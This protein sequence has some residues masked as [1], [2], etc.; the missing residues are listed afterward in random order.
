MCSFLLTWDQAHW[1][2]PRAEGPLLWS[3]SSPPPPP[4]LGWPAA[5]G[6]AGPRTGISPPSFG[7]SPASRNPGWAGS[8]WRH[9][10]NSLAEPEEN[11]SMA[12][13]SDLERQHLMFNHFNSAVTMDVLN[14]RRDEDLMECWQIPSSLSSLNQRGSIPVATSFVTAR[15]FW[16][17]AREVYTPQYQLACTILLHKYIWRWFTSLWYLSDL[18]ALQMWPELQCVKFHTHEFVSPAGVCRC[19]CS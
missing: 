19:P 8:G 3:S 12:G 17:C 15:T 16:E 4:P 10:H 11:Q 1:S 9:R 7:G 14:R 18:P 2:Q 5:G 6:S 13:R